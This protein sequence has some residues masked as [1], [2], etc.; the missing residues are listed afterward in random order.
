MEKKLPLHSASATGCVRPWLH[1]TAV[2]RRWPPPTKRKDP[3]PRMSRSQDPPV[4]RSTTQ[5]CK[6]HLEIQDPPRSTPQISRSTPRNSRFT[7]IHHPECQDPQPEIQDPPQIFKIH[8]PD[9]QDP[10]RKCPCEVQRNR[11]AAPAAAPNAADSPAPRNSSSS[12]E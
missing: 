2:T 11:T 1:N 4:A 6:I 8:H 9:I 5:K 12:S 10:H 3:P 7:K